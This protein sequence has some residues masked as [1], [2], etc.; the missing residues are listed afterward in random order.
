MIMLKSTGLICRDQS[1]ALK[2]RLALVFPSKKIKTNLKQEL[3]IPVLAWFFFEIDLR[4]LL[5]KTGARLNLKIT[6]LYLC[7]LPLDPEQILQHSLDW[8]S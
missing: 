1:S 8:S 7:I 5:I 4:I 6:H 3:N 2:F